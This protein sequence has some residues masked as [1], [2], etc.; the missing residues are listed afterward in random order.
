MSRLGLAVA[1]VAA[2]AMLRV[3]MRSVRGGEEM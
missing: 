3:R 1:I 2:I